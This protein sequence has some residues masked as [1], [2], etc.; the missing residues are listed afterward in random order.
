MKQVIKAPKVTKYQPRQLASIVLQFII[1]FVFWLVLSGHYQAEFIILGALS[2][3]LVTVLT[4]DLVSFVFHRDEREKTELRLTF[5]R[6][7]RF[8]TYLL[9]LFYQIVLANVQIAYII[10]NPRMPI[11]P[12][13]LQ[14]H[15]R[16][17]R[18]FAQVIVA[19]SITLTPGT[20]TIS[21]KDGRYVVHTLVPSSAEKILKADMQ[22]KVGAIFLE[23]KEPPSTPLWAYSLEELEP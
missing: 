2:A 15:T 6:V 11:A 7:G 16:L 5:V 18:T 4:H 21:L 8:F 12:A 23:E 1:L 20:I 17:Q 10:L 9:W 19:N 14:F 3:G 13:F 22:N